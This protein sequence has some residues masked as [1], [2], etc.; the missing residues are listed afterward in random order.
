VQR[1]PPYENLS[2]WLLKRAAACPTRLDRSLRRSSSPDRPGASVHEADTGKALTFTG[3]RLGIAIGVAA[4]VVAM[5]VGGLWL[6]K[7]RAV[8]NS[9]A[10]SLAEKRIAV[11]PFE[12]LGASEDTYFADGMTDEVRQRTVAVKRYHTSRSR[13]ISP[14]G[15]VVAFRAACYTNLSGA[16]VTRLRTVVIWAQRLA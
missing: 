12:N 3:R 14:G 13:A 11:L 8:A 2:T 15:L 4:V 7:G 6:T 1:G 16:R 9:G 10:A 5:V